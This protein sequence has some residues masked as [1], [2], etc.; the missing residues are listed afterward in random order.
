MNI[1][2]NQEKAAL[3]QAANSLMGGNDDAVWISK[4]AAGITLMEIFRS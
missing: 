4:R 2:D 1:L 3:L